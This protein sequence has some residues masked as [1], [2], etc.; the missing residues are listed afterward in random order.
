MT[1]SPS[2]ATTDAARREGLPSGSRL[3]STRLANGLQVLAAEVPDARQLRLVGAVGAGYLDEPMAYRGLAH[4]LEHALFLGSS[5]FPDVG[6]LSR[7]VGRQGGRYNACTD[8]ATTDFHLYLPPEAAEE[9]LARLV[10]LLAH[11]L[12][13]PER[14]KREVGV[15]D[16]EYSARLADPALH[17]LA[18]LGRLYRPGHPGRACHAGNR[19]TLGQDT[20]RLVGNL[21]DFHRRYYRPERMALV[22]LGPLP[23]ELQLELLTHHG[24]EMDASAAST[25]PGEGQAQASRWGEPGGIVWCLPETI[26][27]CYASTLELFWPLPDDLTRAHAEWLDA[28]VTRLADGTL[29]ATLQSAFAIAALDVSLSSQG[30][31]QAL[32]IRLGFAELKPQH[33]DDAFLSMLLATCNRGLEH[34]LEQSMP[35]PQRNNSDLDAWPRRQAQRLV[36]QAK[37]PRA[38]ATL[39]PRAAFDV[40]LTPRQCRW[41]WHCPSRDSMSN[42]AWKT[43]EETGT[44]YRTLPLPATTQ[45]A[46]LPPRPAPHIAVE[47]SPEV[48]PEEVG[49][50]SNAPGCLHH[51]RRLTLWWGSPVWPDSGRKAGWC[52][53]WPAETTEHRARLAQWQRH[54]LPLRQAA[55]AHGL[56]LLTGSDPRGDWLLASGDPRRLTS[57][58]EQAL[59]HWLTARRDAPPTATHQATGL[60]AQRLLCELESCSAP[61]AIPRSTP[62]A[63]ILE[64]ASTLLCWAR[65]RLDAKTARQNAHRFA[66][67][68]PKAPP[69]HAAPSPLN[70]SDAAKWGP[71]WLPPQ[72]SDQAVMLEIAGHDDTPR[73]RFLLQL[74]AQCHDAAFQHAM[75]QRHGFGYVAA[76]RYREAAGWPRL[77]YVVQSPHTSVET[78]RLAIDNF[79]QDRGVALACLESSEFS[80]RLGR[81]TASQ[82]GPETRLEGILLTWQALRRRQPAKARME[83]GN[84]PWPPPPWEEEQAA[85]ASL[86]AGD[87]TALADALVVS[88]LPRRWWFHAPR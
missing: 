60:I 77:G 21:Q 57:V 44:R 61:Q 41:L 5:A 8:E 69:P 6:E 13:E 47:P 67:L 71:I 84:A 35:P 37:H 38:D 45:V 46:A 10:A 55:E 33:D 49:A 9:G 53:G 63:G 20:D 82:G 83:P 39:P 34:A 4:L 58:V 88:D 16:A 15:L 68:L 81:L 62:L 65:G 17:R 79:L 72:G 76:V 14:I 64:P 28:L 43:L 2:S 75:R 19:A 3:Q 87:L 59:K 1:V 51:D 85:L 12:L 26:A 31:G 56:T 24:H 80:Q 36:T 18:A 32:G 74:M 25:S 30:T 40:W 73:S 86:S 54:C 50:D 29:A 22:M 70:P 27:G 23:L 52:L 66:D 48:G 11:P 78:V 42:I 7:W